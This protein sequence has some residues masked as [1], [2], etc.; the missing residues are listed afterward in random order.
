MTVCFL[1]IGSNLGNRRAYIQKALHYMKALKKTK[2]I[3]MSSII[4][5]LPQGGPRGQ[6]K[7]LNAVVKI[8]T[9]IPPV[10]LL[11]AL[12]KIEKMLGRVTKVRWGARVID[13]D[14]LFYGDRIIRTPLLTIPHPR[15][16][17]RDFVMTP[18]CE[19]I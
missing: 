4:E 11:H 13:L 3:R 9:S 19:V 6:G 10:K 12:K 16:F 15:M 14:I 5:T 1:G 2:I 17:K 8:E 7:F 18:L